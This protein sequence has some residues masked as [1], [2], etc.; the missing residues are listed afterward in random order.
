MDLKELTH[1]LVALDKK[2]QELDELVKDIRLKIYGSFWKIV[3]LKK[4]KN[5]KKKRGR[6]NC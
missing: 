2:A 4:E 6:L 3:E 1:A 5:T